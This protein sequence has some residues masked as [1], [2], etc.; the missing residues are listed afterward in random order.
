MNLDQLIE[1]ALEEIEVPPSSKSRARENL[2]ALAQVNGVVAIEE[3]IKAAQ[4]R[5]SVA[6]DWIIARREERTGF[7]NPLEMAEAR[8]TEIQQKL[9]HRLSEVA[10]GMTSEKEWARH[11]VE[12]SKEADQVGGWQQIAGSTYAPAI[13]KHLFLATRAG[14]FEQEPAF[15]RGSVFAEAANAL[16]LCG[17]EARRQDIVEE[18]LVLYKNAVSTLRE[19]NG[20][21]VSVLVAVIQLNRGTTLNGFGWLVRDKFHN[22][23]ADVE[24]VVSHIKFLSPEVLEPLVAQ[25]GS[26][27]AV[28]RNLE[29]LQAMDR[30]LHSHKLNP[31]AA[32]VELLA[33]TEQ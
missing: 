33:P 3:K 12:A 2:R 32:P 9:R 10:R 28:S 17:L 21:S 31:V 11:F 24:S 5:K 20:A 1:R 29:A 4:S 16:S 8:V 19:A 25:Y 18:S 22:L 26:I 6:A 23:A 13:C 27:D 7:S 15:I 30:D 14:D